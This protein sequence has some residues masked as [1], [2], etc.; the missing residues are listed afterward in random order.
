MKAY[1]CAALYPSLFFI[2]QNKRNYF[3]M[4]QY[5]ILDVI[6]TIFKWK[7]AIIYTC[8]TVLI[9]SVVTAFLLPVYYESSTSFFVSST[10]QF[11]PELLYG[12]GTKEIRFYGDDT[13]I[14]RVLTLAE[15]DGMLS[16][17]VDSFHL[18]QHYNI[19]PDKPKAP[20][21]VKLTLSKLM[22]V[23]RT[24]KDAVVLKIQ[25]KD[26]EVAK[27]MVTALRNRI[28]AKSQA[29][30]KETQAAS[31]QS[32]KDDIKAKSTLLKVLNDSLYNLRQRYGIFNAESQTEGLSEQLFN[33]EATLEMN[34]TRLATLRTI[35]GI[36]RD[37]IRMLEAKVKGLES[38]TKLVKEKVELLNSGIGQISA[39]EE[40]YETASERLS[41]DK[42]RLKRYE[43]TF[44]AN[45][46]ALI[47]IEDAK[48]PIIKARPKRKLIVL[49]SVILAFLFSVI[50]VL[51]IDN[52]KDEDWKSII[53]GK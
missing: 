41:E 1:I 19:N 31:I 29:L 23:K 5:N 37:T 17:L 11:K 4:E 27:E 25:D 44:N 2:L 24:D 16:F 12:N 50:G 8:V 51:L 53:H 3:S 45:K 48:T 10:D 52:W 28:N 40:E 47:V 34:K 20:Y 6:K 22:D 46:E 14:D 49:A 36:P 43:A 7:K 30:I 13:D 42:E 26:K 21:Y 18:Y 38:K 15:S 33:T 35:G 32:F 39:L 9:G